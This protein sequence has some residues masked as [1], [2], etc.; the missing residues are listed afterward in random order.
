MEITDRAV[1]IFRLMRQ[2]EDAG[3]DGAVLRHRE[4]LLRELKIPAGVELFDLSIEDMR[5]W[6]AT[7]VRRLIA[8]AR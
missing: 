8:R 2:A 1:A 3:D 5:P 4:R 7:L 6:V